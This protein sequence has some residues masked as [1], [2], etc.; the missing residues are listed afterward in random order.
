MTERTYAAICERSQGWWAIRIPE[1][2]GAF[3]LAVGMLP[4]AIHPLVIPAVEAVVTV[5]GGK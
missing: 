4:R 3:C 2:R 5:S 1:V